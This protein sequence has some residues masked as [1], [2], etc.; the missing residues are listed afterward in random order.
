M[1]KIRLQQML[2]YGYH[3][4][5]QEETKLGQRFIV[6]LALSLDLSKAGKSD[7]LNDTVNY[8][9]VY[10][11]CREIVEGEPKQLIEAVAEQI[12]EEVLNRFMPI[13]E[14]HI[15]FIKPDPPIPGYYQSVSVELTRRKT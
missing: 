3:G 7:D 2:F 10:N 12:C 6:D 13:Q 4:V 14:C 15:K 9:E 11:L 5:L 8:F 1:D